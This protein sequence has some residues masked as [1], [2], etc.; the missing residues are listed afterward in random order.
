MKN[1]EQLK[2]ERLS[3]IEYIHDLNAIGKNIQNCKFLI[4]I[5]SLEPVYFGTNALTV[6]SIA[7]NDLIPFILMRLYQL[8]QPEAVLKAITE[9]PILV[10]E[11]LQSMKVF[12]IPYI[13]FH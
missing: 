7:V 12:S 5:D 11:D 2:L 3:Q 6:D 4:Y 10:I 1:I 9:K 8:S 13:I